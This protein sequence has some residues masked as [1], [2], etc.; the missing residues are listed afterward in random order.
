MRVLLKKEQPEADKEEADD[1]D[2]KDKN[3]RALIDKLA[4]L[5]LDFDLKYVTKRMGGDD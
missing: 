5:I 3:R 2:A 1:D 4:A